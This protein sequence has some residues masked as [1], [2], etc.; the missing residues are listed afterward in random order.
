MSDEKPDAESVDPRAIHTALTIGPALTCVG[1]AWT[2]L[3]PST[4]SSAA[5]LV[6]FATAM[7]GTHKFGRQGPE[8]PLRFDDSAAT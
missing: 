3:S 2:C 4:M 1:I 5:V 7:W 8:R 6:G